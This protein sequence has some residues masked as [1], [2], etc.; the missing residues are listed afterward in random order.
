MSWLL[1]LD[2]SGHDHKQMPYEVRG[3]VA[4]HARE[5]W[6][7]VQAMRRLEF[8][9]F[10]CELS[11]YGHELKGCSLVDRKRFK[12]AARSRA[13]PDDSR[14]KLCRSH[15][16]K[17]LEKKQSSCD[18]LTAY[19]QA[20]ILMADN[21]FQLLRSHQAAIFA[22]AIPRGVRKPVGL[23]A[24][25]PDE[26]LR[27]DQVFLLERYFC[28]LETKREYGLLVMDEV[29][30]SED[31]R[32]VRRLHRYFEKTAK[33]K[34]RS[35]WIVPTPF[36][37]SSD[38]THAVQ[39][40]DLCIYCINWGF[41][42]KSL[43]MDAVGRDEISSRFGYWLNELQYRGQGYHEGNVFDQFGIVF[44]PDPYTRR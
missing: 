13:V 11:E 33:G 38:L 7:F 21:I 30:K 40:A 15:F 37:V 2:E 27:K 16:T 28:F 6:P 25:E 34:H 14:R 8:D 36:F 20:C 26:F 9:C 22:A 31:R 19:G 10:G 35:A 18:E 1:L 39:A 32:F 42:L 44:V 17:G 3:G 43:G 29:E 5:L 12:L 41:R 23:P 24:T 4:M